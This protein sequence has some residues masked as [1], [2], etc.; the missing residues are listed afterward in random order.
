MKL[1]Y[2]DLET[3]GLPLP[4]LEAVMPEFS[5]PA[6]WKD[7]DKIREKK[8]E[9]KAAWLERTALSPMTGRV[10][11]AIWIHPDG[12]LQIL[13][14]AKFGE[15]WLLKTLADL[16]RA[17]G[18]GAA[19]KCVDFNGRNFDRP[20]FVRRCWANGIDLPTGFVSPRGKWVDWAPYLIDL[21]DLWGLGEA[22][23][24]GS[25]ADVTRFLG[26]GLKKGSGADFAR[27]WRN[28]TERAE[29]EAYLRNDGL[30]L[31]RIT[32][33]LLH[34]SPDHYG[35]RVRPSDTDQPNNQ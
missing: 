7:P 1:S 30:L 28:P 32:E 3:E 8:E 19:Y 4:E 12:E 6:N 17:S 33:K 34:L 35:L 16:F 2:W 27:M 11:A 31:K 20:F 9:Q 26:A 25:L 18:M 21:R 29:A 5:A 23:P 14:G 22:F 24:D 10:L 15:P 13:D